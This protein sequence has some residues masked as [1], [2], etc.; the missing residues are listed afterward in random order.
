MVI[1]VHPRTVSLKSIAEGY[2]GFILDGEAAEDSSGMVNGAGDVNDDGY[3][4]V[5]IDAM[6]AD[7]NGDNSGRGYIVFGGDFD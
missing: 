5:L 1:S 6:N 2:G 7:P 3:A 4:D